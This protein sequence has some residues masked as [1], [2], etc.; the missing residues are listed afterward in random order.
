MINYFCIDA[1]S[2]GVGAMALTPTKSYMEV[3]LKTHEYDSLNIQVPRH[4][5]SSDHCIFF[6]LINT[7]VINKTPINNI[8]LNII[9]FELI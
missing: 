1:N 2:E 5:H 4:K 9:W 6:F 8:S 7:V 3:I